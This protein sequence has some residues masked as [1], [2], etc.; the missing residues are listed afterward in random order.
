MTNED[1]YKRSNQRPSF[2][3]YYQDVAE[4]IRQQ[5]IEVSTVLT[6]R[7]MATV[8]RE[9]T[10]MIYQDAL[11]KLSRYAMSQSDC[12]TPADVLECR[13]ILM[14]TKGEHTKGEH[15]DKAGD[16]SVAPMTSDPELLRQLEM[17]IARTGAKWSDDQQCWVATKK[18]IDAPLKII[19]EKV[20]K[21]ITATGGTWPT[22]KVCL[23]LGEEV[24]E[25]F[26]ARRKE[27]SE[28]IASE[29][30][31]VLLTLVVFANDQKINLD[32]VITDRIDHAY[33]IAR[34]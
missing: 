12:L 10:A 8:S 14:H 29:V 22:D 13:K 20:D 26:R 34:K 11:N 24:G 32:A 5:D 9:E 1:I 4:F 25:L 16:I 3:R 31:D 33:R 28:R 21:C 15:T 7:I 17:L 2:C 27:S 19:Q 30:G 23:R 18:A 6:E